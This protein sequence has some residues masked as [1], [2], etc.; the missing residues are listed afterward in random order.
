MVSCKSDL[1]VEKLYLERD[2]KSLAYMIIEKNFK[3][4]I[5]NYKYQ[6]KK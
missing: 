1:R 2:F 6:A 3:A 4:L 5:K